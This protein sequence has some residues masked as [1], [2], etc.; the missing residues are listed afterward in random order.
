MTEKFGVVEIE[1]RNPENQRVME[2]N[3]SEDAAETYIKIAVMRRGV[4]THFYKAVSAGM[5]G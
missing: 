5:A 1:I 2:R 4:E 3:L